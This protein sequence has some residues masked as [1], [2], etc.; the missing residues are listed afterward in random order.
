[1]GLAFVSRA[2]QLV[3]SSMMLAGF[4]G[5]HRTNGIELESLPFRALLE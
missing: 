2:L 4:Y 1:M 3:V 5:L